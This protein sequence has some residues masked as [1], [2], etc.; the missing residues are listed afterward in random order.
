[1][2]EI[3]TQTSRSHWERIQA[4][5]TAEQKKKGLIKKL[6]QKLITFFVVCQD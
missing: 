2:A 6:V 5:F 3:S 4:K 1:M